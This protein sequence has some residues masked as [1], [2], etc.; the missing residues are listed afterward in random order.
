LQT[1][2]LSNVQCASHSGVH[3]TR[4]RQTTI[5]I[6]DLRLYLDYWYL[7]NYKRIVCFIISL[8]YVL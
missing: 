5:F 8:G 1:E 4:V 6:N 2:V 3:V 7:H